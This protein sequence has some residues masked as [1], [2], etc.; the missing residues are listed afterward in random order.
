MHHSTALHKLVFSSPV[1]VATNSTRLTW[2]VHLG[3]PSMDARSAASN[4]ICYCVQLV[5]VLRLSEEQLPEAE[6]LHCLKLFTNLLSTQV[7]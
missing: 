4:L 7:G 5:S 6:R 1:V 2:S 3:R